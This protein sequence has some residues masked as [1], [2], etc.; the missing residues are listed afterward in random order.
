M[1]WLVRV[2]AAIVVAALVSLSA[3][4]E[5][6]PAKIAYVEGKALVL[7]KGEKK[8]V[9]AELGMSLFYGD[10]VRVERNS[11]CQVNMTASGILRLSENTTLLLPEEA[12]RENEITLRK[13]FVDPP[14][15]N[16]KRLFED[17]VFEVRGPGIGGIV[18]DTGIPPEIPHGPTKPESRA[19]AIERL[20][21]EGNA[22][23]DA[24]RAELRALEGKAIR[25]PCSNCGSNG[26]HRWTTD[27]WECNCGGTAVTPGEYPTSHGRYN[28]V[29]DDYRRRIEALGAQ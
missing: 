27:G 12:S 21:A 11:K 25:H 19:E 9:P 4:A 28:A 20:R 17:D 6:P 23:L 29:R 7:R 13:M 14:I 24:I 15:R 2:P 3:R 26:P 1:Q 18:S 5:T 8:P 22:K 10:Q 16:F